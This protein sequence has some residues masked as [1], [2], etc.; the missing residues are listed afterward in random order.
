MVG[1]YFLFSYFVFVFPSELISN[2]ISQH[3]SQLVRVKAVWEWVQR[4]LFLVNLRLQ[5]DGDA[6]DDD[7]E[8]DDGDEEEEEEDV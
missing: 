6:N 1:S 5:E 3:L 8:D 2:L 7:D 4:L